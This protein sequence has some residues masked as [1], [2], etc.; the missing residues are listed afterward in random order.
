MEYSNKLYQVRARD[1]RKKYLIYYFEVDESSINLTSLKIGSAIDGKFQLPF[2]ITKLPRNWKFIY[3]KTKRAIVIQFL[4]QFAVP[5]T[6]NPL[7]FA[8]IQ[9]TKSFK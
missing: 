1:E 8:S 4:A 7:W 6:K 9:Q 2:I 3:T 5:S